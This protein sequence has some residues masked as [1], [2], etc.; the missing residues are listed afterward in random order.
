MYLHI[1]LEKFNYKYMNC[2]NKIILLLFTIYLSSLFQK[3][4]IN[5]Y[6]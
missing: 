3:S 5:L 4:Y 1:N 2:I 6:F